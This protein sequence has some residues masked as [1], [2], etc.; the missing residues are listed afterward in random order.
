MNVTDVFGFYFHGFNKVF[1]I[2]RQY[3]LSCFEDSLPKFTDR[4]VQSQSAAE[5]VHQ[6]ADKFKDVFLQ[7]IRCLRSQPYA[8][9]SLT[10]R[11]IL[12]MREQCLSEYGFLDPYLNQKNLENEQAFQLLEGVLSDLRALPERDLIEQVSVEAVD[13][14]LKS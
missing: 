5:G 6:R 3:W 8:H 2:L 9:G 14:Y 10:V 4:A 7:R 1:V 12:V 13:Y 11:N